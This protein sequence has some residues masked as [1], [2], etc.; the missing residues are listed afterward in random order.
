MVTGF[1]DRLIRRVAEDPL[2]PGFHVEMMPSSV[3]V[4]MAS[5]E[6]STTDAS[7]LD[8]LFGVLAVG[9]VLDDAD[10]LRRFAV[11][12]AQ[13]RHRRAAPH[14]AA[15]LAQV[16][17]LERVVVDLA[18]PQLLYL[19]RAL[20]RRHP[21]ASARERCAGEVRR[22]NSREWSRTSGWLPGSGR[23]DSRPRCRAPPARTP[24]SGAASLARSARS[25]VRRRLTSWNTMTAPVILPRAS[26]I[27]AAL[28]SMLTSIPSREISAV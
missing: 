15:V 28:S 25:A 2:A 11:F 20:H 22:A 7:R 14:R 23:R 1:A 3:F 26:R 18:G 16:T 9:D 27:G 4:M 5:S 10:E 12:L 6:Y 13:Q 17:F 19:R 21:G 24:R 8:T